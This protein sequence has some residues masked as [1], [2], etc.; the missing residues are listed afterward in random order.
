MAS[1]R[2][3]DKNVRPSAPVSVGVRTVGCK[4]P[5][6]FGL[7]FVT[8]G[9][10]AVARRGGE[11]PEVNDQSVGNELDSACCC[12][13]PARKWRSPRTLRPTGTGAGRPKGRPRAVSPGEKTRPRS[14]GSKGWLETEWS[15]V[16]AR[17]TGRPARHPGRRSCAVMPHAAAT[18]VRRTCR[19]GVRASIVARK[20]G[21]AGGAKGRREVNGE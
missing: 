17:E 18:R 14:R 5:P 19:T 21:N 15:E 8:N 11:Q 12:G 3:T 10:C 1:G 16:P 2:L 20:P 6:K 13:E 9:N 4:S 7:N